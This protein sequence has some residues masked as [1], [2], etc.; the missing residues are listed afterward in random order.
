LTVNGGGGDEEDFGLG[1][2]VDEALCGEEIG[3]AI[4]FFIASRGGEGV[5]EEGGVLGEGGRLPGLRSSEV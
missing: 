2:V 4:G 1:V 3:V 5:D